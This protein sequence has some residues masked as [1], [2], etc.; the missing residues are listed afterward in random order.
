M[1]NLG[2]GSVSAT[3]ISRDLVKGRRKSKMKVKVVGAKQCCDGH[4]TVRRRDL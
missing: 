4:P 1:P 2:I 3:L